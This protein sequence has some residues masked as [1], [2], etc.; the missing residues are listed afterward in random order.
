MKKIF[1]ALIILIILCDCNESEALISKNAL[2]DLFQESSNNQQKIVS[3]LLLTRAPKKTLKAKLSN[4]SNS[5]KSQKISSLFMK[6]NP[7]LTKTLADEY[8][9]YVIEAAEKFNQDPYVIAAIIIHESTVNNKAVSKGGDYGLMQVRWRV[10]EKSIKQR[11]PNVKKS[12]DIF[13]AKTNILY[14]TEIFSQCMSK[15]NNTKQAL[16]KYS[17]GSNKLVSKVLKTVKDLNK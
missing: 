7:A 9:S 17:A 10:H 8:A 14:G 15:T 3:E 1:Y 16:L 13:D 6:I 5:S 12:K 4:S 2:E 11:F